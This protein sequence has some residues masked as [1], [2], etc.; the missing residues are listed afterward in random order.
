MFS[1][2]EKGFHFLEEKIKLLKEVCKE[3]GFRKR[4]DELDKILERLKSP[5]LITVFGEVNAG[6]SSFLNALLGIPDLCRTDVDICTDRITVVNY[7]ENPKRE[8]ID[9]I[10]EKVC[11]NNPLLKGFTVVDTPGINSVLEHHTYITEKFLPK[12]DVILVILPAINPHTKQIWDWIAKISK[13]YGKKIVFVLQQKDLVNSEEN[14]KRLEQKVAEYARERG[15]SEPKVFSVSALLEL[16]GER[17]KSGFH[18]LREFLKENYTGEKQIKEKLL[19]I[20]NEL[21]KLYTDCVKEL[22]NLLEEA[23]KIKENLEGVLFYVK[24]RIKE[25][26]EYKKLLLESIDAE[27]NRLSERIA[28]K[29]ER[30]SLLDLA[31]RKGKVKEFL[32]SLKVELE[33]ELETFVRNTLLPKFELFESAVI[34]GAVEDAAKR[35]KEFERFYEKLGK[36]TS[37]LEEREI[38]KILDEKIGKVE[39]GGGEEA[40]AVMGGSILAGSL[41]MLLSGSFMVDITGGVISSLG[42][43]L[44]LG[45][46]MRKRGNLK[47]ELNKILQ[48]EI[49]ERLKKEVSRIV[50]R[51]IGETLEVMRQYLEDRIRLIEK[52]IENLQKAKEKILSHYG[53]LKKFNP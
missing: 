45:Y 49:G 29:I 17:E 36:K 16:Q 28:E 15:I 1:V 21:L 53:E 34:R 9:E 38:L 7:C 5:F 32:D 43:L 47:R 2:S 3:F 22:D 31:F 30:L 12:S 10:T 44:G 20:R 52:E 27:I 39:I 37:P 23:K 40:V 41:M 51:R 48:T 26:Q 18:P 19:G 11:I 4:V 35:L 8:K 25:A 46:L 6:K 13:D 33:K 42:I 24:K 50:D 14:L